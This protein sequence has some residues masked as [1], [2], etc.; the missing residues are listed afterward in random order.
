[1]GVKT[2]KQEYFEKLRTLLEENKS[3][4]IV[5]VDNVRPLIYW[6][7]QFT[8]E[9]VAVGLVTANARDS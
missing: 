2:N 1:M 3:I 6:L 4:F 8:D 7:L 5:S 9:H